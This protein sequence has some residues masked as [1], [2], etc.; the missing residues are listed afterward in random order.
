MKLREMWQPRLLLEGGNL[1]VGD[2]QADRIDSSKRSQVVPV[3]QKFIT[4]LNVAYSQTHDGPIWN[5]D[6]IASGQHLAGSSFHFFSRP[7][8]TDE[9]FAGVKRT[10]G[11]IDLKVDSK[12]N[13]QIREW[14]ESLSRGAKIGPARFID[15]DG[16]DPEQALT[17]WQFPD[18]VITDKEGSEK[19]INIQIDLEMKDY[20]DGKPTDWAGFSTSSAWEDLSEGIKGVFHKFLIQSLSVLTKQ[21]FVLQK[22]RKVRGKDE[23]QPSTRQTVED[24]MVSFA[25]KSS[26]GGGLRL[27]Y[28]PVTDPDTGEQETEDGLPVYKKRPTT[29]YEKDLVEIFYALFNGGI[30]RETLEKRKRELWSFVGLLNIVKNVLPEDQQLRVAQSFSQK[31]FGKGAQGLYKGDPEK[32]R[33]EKT[34]AMRKLIDVLEVKPEDLDQMISDYYDTYKTESLEED[35]ATSKRKGVVHL[36]KMKDLDFLEF[37]EEIQNKQGDGFDLANIKM[38]TKIDGLGGRFGKDSNGEPFFESSRSGPIKTAG[39]FSAHMEKQGVDDPEKLARAEKYDSLFDDI[40]DLI[41][42]IDRELGEDFLNNV[43]VHCEIL[44][45]PMATET[46]EGRLQYVSME[47]DKLPDGVD[48]AV[49]PLFVEQADTGEDH[50][51]NDEIKQQLNELGRLGNAQF[52]DNSILQQGSL[53]V[54]TILEPLENIDELK[55]VV[56]SRK[57]KGEEAER[58]QEIKKILDRMKQQIAREVVENPNIVGKYKLG[59]DYEGVILYTKKGPIKVTSPKFKELMKKKQDTPKGGGKAIV[60]YGNLMGHK[61]HQLLVDATLKMAQQQNRTPFIY[62]SPMVGPDDPVSPETKKATFQKLYPAHKQAF[63]IVGSGA[64]AKGVVRS[65]GIRGA[66]KFD[67]APEGFTD[68]VVVTG[69]DQKDAFKFLTTD[70]ARKSMGVDSVDTVIRQDADSGE[71]GVRSTQLRNILKNPNLSYEQ[72]VNKWMQGFDGKNLGREWIEKLMAEAAK[73][74]SLDL[75]ANSKQKES[76]MNQPELKEYVNHLENI[77][78]DRLNEMTEEEKSV[79]DEIA[80]AI[81]GIE[82][83]GQIEVD[84]DPGKFDMLMQAA[85]KGDFDQVA[86]IIADFVRSNEYAE[87]DAEVASQAALEEIEA[88]MQ[89]SESTFEDEDFDDE[90]GEEEPVNKG[91]SQSPM[92]DQLGKVLDSQD[93]PKPVNTVTTDDGETFEV[94]QDQARAL[95]LLATTEKV[96]PDVKQEFLRDLQTSQGL[97]DYLDQSDYH[98]MA[99]LFVK[100]Y[101]A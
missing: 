49:V 12:K 95:R 99:H 45:V 51:R 33:E 32:D 61:G 40:M 54:T 62:I 75:K 55:S 28:D 94:N 77:I 69:E 17:L 81:Q 5:D 84:I 31:L 87:R 72:K 96:K 22:Y 91:F 71:E 76:I 30:D 29:G 34:I 46:P 21:E 85:R 11:D 92:F 74:M 52:I 42:D 8:I 26:E 98:E 88:I 39:A 1:V 73:N 89:Q 4:S 66:I 83:F 63:R 37:V 50:P 86:E 19:P 64:D 24:S 93:S 3:L 68:I 9:I 18:L 60:A 53:D 79:K 6:V 101:L 23:Y 78:G 35:V 41:N 16:K 100:R 27:K 43:K 57:R 44:Y 47:Y 2:A 38:T 97:S 58:K 25:I 20:E 13:K 14:L 56:Q 7:E 15:W 59:D 80:Q 70:R 36:E 48:L 65:G 67:L 82:E 90:E 10:V